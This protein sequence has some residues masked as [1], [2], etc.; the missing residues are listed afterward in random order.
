ML[1]DEPNEMTAD[2]QIRAAAATAAA[3]MYGHFIG[4]AATDTDDL[5]QRKP[6]AMG[7]DALR[8]AQLFEQYIRTGTYAGDQLA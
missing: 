2:Q 8:I 7:E 6:L 3:T 5:Y 4:L 1:N